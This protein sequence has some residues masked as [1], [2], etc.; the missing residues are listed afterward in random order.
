M[1]VLSNGWS[2]DSVETSPVLR[3]LIG[4]SCM[5]QAGRTAQ[6]GPP[7]RCFMLLWWAKG[8]LHTT[9]QLLLPARP[10]SVLQPCTP[11][12]KVGSAPFLATSSEVCQH[13]RFSSLGYLFHE[14]NIS[15]CDKQAQPP[16][17]CAAQSCCFCLFRC[18][19]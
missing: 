3:A 9:A 5:H 15:G 2:V 12:L 11:H 13:W 1:L 10:A 14:V 7:G 6:S 19:F 4:K 17:K 16:T 18:L 8:L